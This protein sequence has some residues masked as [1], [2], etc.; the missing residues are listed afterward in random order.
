M[1]SFTQLTVRSRQRKRV[2]REWAP[3]AGCRTLA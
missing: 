2:L 3:R 1:N